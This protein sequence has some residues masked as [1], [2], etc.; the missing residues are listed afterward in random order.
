M[1][2]LLGY[3]RLIELGLVLADPPSADEVVGKFSPD[4]DPGNVEGKDP[5]K[6]PVGVPAE[7]PAI[8]I[9]SRARPP[10][11]WD[12]LIQPKKKVVWS[13]DLEDVQVLDKNHNPVMAETVI[14]NVATHGGACGEPV[15]GLRGTLTQSYV[16]YEV[17]EPRTSMEQIRRINQEI[18]DGG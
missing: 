10:V 7:L 18:A 5:S 2:I 8:P 9:S 17:D 3:Q 1:G 16:Y 12:P 13:P 11:Y 14:D 6:L 4:P 15:L